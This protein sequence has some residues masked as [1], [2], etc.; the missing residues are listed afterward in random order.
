[1]GESSAKKTNGSVA[2]SAASARIAR[3]L[4]GHVTE[5]AEQV[6]ASAIFV[7]DDAVSG[8]DWQPPEDLVD[9]MIYVIRE[10]HADEDDS[11]RPGRKLRVPSVPLGRVGQ[12]KIA[13]FL[14]LSRGLIN[15]G[16]MI[17]FV[18][19][20]AGSLDTVLVSE[21]GMEFE[22]V[23]AAEETTRMPGEVSPEVLERLIDIAAELGYQGRE[24]KP[25]GAIF[26]L[27]DSEKVLGLSRQMIL[28]PF[29]GYPREQRNILDATI[30]ETVKEL[31]SVDG[32]FVIHGDG[33]IETCGAYLKTA[34]QQEYE[35]PRGLGTRH[36]AA[37]AITAVTDAVA[38]TVSESTGTV[39]IFRGGRTVTDIEK[40]RQGSAR[41]K[42][43]ESA[44]QA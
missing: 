5:I 25:V 13:V 8:V 4:L 43:G 23:A 10:T 17:V 2:T 15:P 9:K 39:T 3:C 18:T 22:M 32:A 33:V 21:V 34:S 35:L 6:Q 19:G 40:P 37:A 31:A 11:A 24:G 42:G 12:V 36:H 16:D 41:R 1:V 26:V 7:Y 38:V 30:E 44:A 20:R 28:N 14:A 29:Q 27:G